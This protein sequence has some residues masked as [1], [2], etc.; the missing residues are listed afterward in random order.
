MYV[1]KRPTPTQLDPVSGKIYWPT[2][3]RDPR[4]DDYRNK[5][6]QFVEREVS[7][8]GIGYETYTKIVQV[9]N[10]LLDALR[11]TSISTTTAT[12]SG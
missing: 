2:M 9:T 11:K 6:D 7:H 10:S 3:L 4:Y 8:G 1:P 12:T 5:I